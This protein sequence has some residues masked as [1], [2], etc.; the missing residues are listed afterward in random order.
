MKPRMISIPLAISDVDIKNI[1]DMSEEDF[2]KLSQDI[3]TNIIKHIE[4]KR[5]EL[6]PLIDDLL[7]ILIN[8]KTTIIKIWQKSYIYYRHF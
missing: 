3:N 4:D 7:V 2:N 8:K 6:Y 5:K 1:G